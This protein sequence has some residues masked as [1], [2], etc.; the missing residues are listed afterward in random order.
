MKSSKKVDIHEI[1]PIVSA[2]IT[3]IVLTTYF[4][5]YQSPEKIVTISFPLSIIT[6][7]AAKIYFVTT[8]I[9]EIKET[10]EKINVIDN[11]ID[12]LVYGIQ[13][14]KD[15]GEII[16]AFEK[17]R[18]T[19]NCQFI[20]A[21]W[22][23]N[24]G[25]ALKIDYFK[26]EIDRFLDSQNPLQKVKRIINKKIF[27]PGTSS[28]L[29]HNLYDKN[30]TLYKEYLGLLEKNQLLKNNNN[31]AYELYACDDIDAIEIF[32]GEFINK[33]GVSQPKAIIVFNNVSKSD[34][35]PFIGL[36]IDPEE[37]E[38]GLR[39]TL[40]TLAYSIRELFDYILKKSQKIY[41][42]EQNKHQT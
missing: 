34:I 23:A 13:I 36:L 19:P 4:Q 35:T 1:L 41:P 32:Y 12:K 11:K 21:I 18:N 5:L 7:I 26:E 27:N 30:Y 31:K 42:P 25:N 14:I 9:K 28:G 38:E 33:Q 29:Q 22:S 16:A 3:G 15:Y 6:Y 20:Y 39:S 40:I 24:Y 17:L 2:F 10:T 37:S 8:S